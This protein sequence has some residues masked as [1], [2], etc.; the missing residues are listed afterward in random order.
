MRGR[1]PARQ[2]A[3]IR[4][5]EGEGEAEAFARL[6]DLDLAVEDPGD[7]DLYLGL[8][9]RTG[10][11]VLELAAGTGRICVPIASQGLAVTAVDIDPAM[12]ARAGERADAAGVTDR[13]TLVE[14]D[15]LDLE[16]LPLPDAGGFRLAILALNSLFLLADREAQAAALRVMAPHLAPGGLAVVDIW[17]PSAADLEVYDGRLILD[18]ARIDDD[19][20]VRTKTWAATHDPASGAVT[21]TTIHESGPPGAP[22]ARWVRRDAM[23]LVSP[24]ELRGHAEAAGLEVETLA[25]DRALSPLRHDSERAVLIASRPDRSTPDD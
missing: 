25:G 11:P 7:L 22:P 14:A 15:L 16:T 20:T 13:L 17:L 2:R 24:T 1:D 23:R 21:V 8:A 19:G 3:P 5:G 18:D 4:S 9:R 10:G 6:Y 12:L